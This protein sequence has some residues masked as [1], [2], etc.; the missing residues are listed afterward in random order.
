MRP[1]GTGLGGPTFALG[2][3]I[4]SMALLN[5]VLA[6]DLVKMKNIGAVATPAELKIRLECTNAWLQRT[7]S[8]TLATDTPATNTQIGGFDASLLVETLTGS[9]PATRV[10]QRDVVELE[11]GVTAEGCSELPPRQRQL[12]LEIP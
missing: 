9:G 1:T 10:S 2:D 11:R 12:L 3:T 4:N 5:A 8:T 7:S 6:G